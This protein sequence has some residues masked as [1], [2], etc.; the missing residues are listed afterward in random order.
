VSTAEARPGGLARLAERLADR[1]RQPAPGRHWFG[2]EHPRPKEKTTVAWLV[3][4]A[5]VGYGVALVAVPGLLIGL[6]GQR[7]GRRDCAVA[8]VLGARHLLQA[9]VTA[10]AQLADPGDSVVLGGGA[11]ADLL[12]ATTMV[13]L[14]VVDPRARRAALID[15]GVETAL[16]VAGAAAATSPG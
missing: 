10:A 5:R 12:H 16:A 3:T 14:G 8:R 9:G 7:P 2:G 13:A 6:T 15:A 4:L 11:A 1:P